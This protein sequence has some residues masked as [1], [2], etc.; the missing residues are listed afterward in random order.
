M[1]GQQNFYVSMENV[2]SLGSYKVL[3]SFKTI[4]YNLSIATCM[5]FKKVLL[6]SSIHLF[7]AC[8]CTYSKPNSMII[9]YMYSVI[10]HVCLPLICHC[11]CV[12]VCACMRAC[13]CGCVCAHVCLHMYMHVCVLVH[14]QMSIFSLQR[15]VKCPSNVFL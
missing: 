3:N 9:C 4:M 2:A 7:T 10:V 8:N 11:V 6:R 5:I 13:V 12:C 15:L 1:W 14:K